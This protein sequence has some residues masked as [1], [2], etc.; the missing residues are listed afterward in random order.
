MKSSQVITIQCLVV[1]MTL[2][3]PSL[4]QT[5]YEPDYTLITEIITE[6]D[7]MTM[8]A[9]EPTAEPNTGLSAGAIAGIAVGGTVVAGGVVGGTAAGVIF[10][11]KGSSAVAPAAAGAV[12]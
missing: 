12:A 4:C 7:T 3:L 6:I 1:L 11:T 2:V 9:V 10:F 8:E 5:T